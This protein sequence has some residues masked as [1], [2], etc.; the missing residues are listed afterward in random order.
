VLYVTSSEAGKRATRY[1]SVSQRV[2]REG[3]TSVASGLLCVF[4]FYYG[5]TLF[6]FLDT[7]NK[8]MKLLETK[9]IYSVSHHI[10][11]YEPNICLY[12]IIIKSTY[13]LY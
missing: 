4:L 13:I 11:K 12:L 9:H 2:C 10:L 8:F 1:A 5:Y 7:C 3:S 6:T